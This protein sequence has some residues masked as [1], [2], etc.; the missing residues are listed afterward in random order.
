V[1]ELALDLRPAML[2]DLGL[3]PALLWRCERYTAQTQV[4]VNFAHTGMAT[5]FPPEVETAAYRIVQEALTN[6]TLHAG[7]N[8]ATVRLWT[9]QNQL[10]VEIQD[11]GN[12]F[13]PDAALAAGATS[14][15]AGMRERALLLG[16]QFTLESAPGNGTRV[17]AKLPLITE[18]GS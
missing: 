11:Q 13:D 17:T 8:E 4:K 14:G 18:Q 7:V 9:D 15:L 5:R 2:D 16:G 6:V 10:V 1:H 12:G 3:I